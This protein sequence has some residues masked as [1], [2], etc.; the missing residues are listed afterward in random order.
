[1]S[2]QGRPRAAGSGQRP[3][4]IELLAGYPVV[5]ESPVAWG[6]MDAFAHVNNTVY[7]RWFESSRIAYFEKLELMELMERTGVGPILASTRCRFKIPLDY[8]DRVSVGARIARIGEDRFVMEYAAA[9]HRH[10]AIAADGEG[11]IVA[12]D[13]R[14]RAKA[15][16]PDEVRE[17]IHRLEGRDPD[18]L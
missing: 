5:I 4:A 13:Y 18:P 8:P 2:G 11:L 17:R 9:S 15:P 1:M 14:Q 16:I 3:A 10:A 12:Y 6:D 7:L